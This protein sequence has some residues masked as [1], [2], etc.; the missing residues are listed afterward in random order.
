VRFDAEQ[1]FTCQQCARCCRR[2]WDIVLTPDELAGYRRARAQRWYREREDAAEGTQV[3]PFDP[4]SGRPEYGRIRKR[5]DG[6]CGFLSPENRC[7]IH[8]ELGAARKPLTCRVFP[9]RFDPADGPAILSASFA[10]PT[11]VRNEGETLS[12]QLTAITTLQREWDKAYPEPEAPLQF[13]KGRP[14]PSGVLGT[15]REVLREM[16]ERPG[17]DG[18][19]DLAA[20]VA[21]MA[22][23]LEDLTRHRVLRLKPDRFVEYL[24]LT[25]RFA[26]RSEKAALRRPASLVS[27]LLFRGFFFVVA[28]GRVQ[29]EHG[30]TWDTRLRLAALALHCHGLWRATQGYDLAAARRVRVDSS[31]PAVRNVAH[32]Y[33]RAQVETLGRGRVPVVD[34]LALAFAFLNAACLL[35]GMRAGQAGR[36]VDGNAFVDGMLEASDLTHSDPR[37]ALGFLL[38]TLSGG[39]DA[40]RLF[41]DAQGAGVAADR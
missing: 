39:V 17:P 12:S 18:A 21:R 40:L 3:E 22:T 2:G 35:A 29:L 26:A 41:C 5:A 33:L 9:Y 31:D 11:V 24:E 15:L 10:C 14:L 27:R 8:E 37:G 38:T 13:V 4:L 32:N 34:E 7:R 25:G 16:L 19:P 6:T 1:R 28:A 36:S 20:N 30:R 23:L